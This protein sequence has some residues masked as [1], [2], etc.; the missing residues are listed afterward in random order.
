MNTPLP[1]LAYLVLEELMY[2]RKAL[3]DYEGLEGT[4]EGSGPWRRHLPEQ[5]VHEILQCTRENCRALCNGNFKIGTGI[6][7]RS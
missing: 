5:T 1:D 7:W 2:I 4:A 3:K 6:C